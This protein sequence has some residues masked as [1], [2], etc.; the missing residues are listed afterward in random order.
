MSTKYKY[1]VVSIGT[2][3]VPSL[4]CY[5]MDI[6]GDWEPF[7]FSFS[8]LRGGGKIILINS[9]LED[10]PTDLNNFFGAWHKNVVIKNPV[11]TL[12]ALDNFG[13]KP[14][15][16]DAIIITPITAYTVGALH[17]FPKADYYFGRK[18][19][20]DFWAGEQDQPRNVP[21]VFMPPNVR[22]HLA[23][24]L[25]NR[26][27]LLE[28]EHGEVFS[29]VR[30][31]FAGGHHRS[32]MAYLVDTEKGVVG[33]TDCV[34]KYPNIEKNIPLGIAENIQENLATYRRLKEEADIIIPPHDPEV[35]DKYKNG[36][37]V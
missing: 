24:N 26:V 22:K 28:D 4:E 5:H 29:G 8:L 35:F 7:M 23:L 6:S 17:H 25:E 33:L 18:G 27:K 12:N 3:K 1:D 21:G 34:F 30:A 37:V 19:W 14:E 13:I 36:K 20:V 16:V 15:E 10:D 11:K 32:S 31:W 2:C 9:G